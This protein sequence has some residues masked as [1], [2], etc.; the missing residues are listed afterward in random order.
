[1]GEIMVSTLYNRARQ[2]V[3]SQTQPIINTSEFIVVKEQTGQE[4][5]KSKQ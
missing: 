2:S 1:M 3:N 4:W 5:G